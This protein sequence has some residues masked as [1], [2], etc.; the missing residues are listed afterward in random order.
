MVSDGLS[1]MNAQMSS[2]SFK[3]SQVKIGDRNYLGNNIFFP[4]AA[5]PAPTACSAPR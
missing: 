1:M 5:R 4:P 3:L 2:S